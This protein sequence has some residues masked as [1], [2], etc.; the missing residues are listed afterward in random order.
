MNKRDKRTIEEWREK[1]R[2][3]CALLQVERDRLLKTLAEKDQRISQL[4][5]ELK[6]RPSPTVQE[7]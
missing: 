5:A 6:S 7:N 2:K 4:E 1:N 3:A